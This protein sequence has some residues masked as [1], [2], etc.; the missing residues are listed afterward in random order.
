[1]KQ[2]HIRREKQRKSGIWTAS[3]TD[4]QTNVVKIQLI[5]KLLPPHTPDT[6]V[7]RCSVC[8]I[9]APQYLTRGKIQTL[10]FEQL[11][12]FPL[13]KK[14]LQVDTKQV[15]IP[16]QAQHRWSHQT[17]YATDQPENKKQWKNN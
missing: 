2:R 3:Q 1:M 8:S 9:Q 6:L 5:T 16:E 15:Y 4:R 13:E 11:N 14:R 12:L 10:R 7:A 17:L